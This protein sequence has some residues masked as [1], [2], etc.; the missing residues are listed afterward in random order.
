MRTTFKRFLLE[1]I[2]LCES[3]VRLDVSV[4]NLLKVLK[5]QQLDH[6]VVVTEKYDGVK[7]TLIRTNTKCEENDY[8]RSVS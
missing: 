3:Q 5:P 4:P 8:A 1:T 7:L 2:D 6:E